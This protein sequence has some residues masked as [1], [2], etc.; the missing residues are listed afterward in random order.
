MSF[1]DELIT[2]FRETVL[3]EN[4]DDAIKEFNGKVDS[5]L[6]ENQPQTL[7]RFRPCNTL[8]F[9]ALL[10]NQYYAS[11]PSQF[12]DPFD[13]FMPTD[14]SDLEE[15]YMQMTDLAGMRK[16]LDETGKLPAYY[17]NLW[18]A[19][20]QASISSKLR[21]ISIETLQELQVIAK[22]KGE[23]DLAR[24]K[25]ETGRYIN[26]VQN[27]AWVA[28]FSEDVNSNLM[29]SHYADY[30]KGFVLEYDF[31]SCK[32]NKAQLENLFPVLYSEEPYNAK[33]VISWF[34]LRD[35][36]TIIPFPDVNY[37]VKACLFKATE[38]AYEKEWRIL[39]QREENAP[40]YESFELI[41]SA[42]FY[43][44]RMPSAD[45]NILH[46]IVKSLGIKEYKMRPVKGNKTYD[47]EAVAL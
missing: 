3:S 20:L 30:H 35:N 33:D 4:E 5:I 11:A 23:Q 38:W 28:C 2:L 29:W 9:D 8:N 1:R 46:T 43:G 40:L 7:F 13:S 18:N 6:K 27:T 21:D 36:G 25:K 41:P 47:M 45:Y 39:K 10:R 37:W 42:I 14:D 24:I 19:D 32:V 22:T 12:N 15:L 26:H 34:V 17:Q 16:A 31:S 44:C